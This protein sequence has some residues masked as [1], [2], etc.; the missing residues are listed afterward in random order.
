MATAT[1]RIAAA[2]ASQNARSIYCHSQSFQNLFLRLALA[3]L[4]VNHSSF[5]KQD[6]FSDNIFQF[7][8]F[9]AFHFLDFFFIHTLD[10]TGKQ[11]G[12]YYKRDHFQRKV[13]SEYQRCH[14]KDQRTDDHSG[15]CEERQ[16]GERLMSVVILEREDGREISLK[17]DDERLYERDINEEDIVTLDENREIWK[18]QP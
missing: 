5:G 6:L 13:V 1:H 11:H 18:V 8:L 7:F 16:P 9:L 4:R 10:H 12:S 2:I 14:K 15:G 3:N 17:H